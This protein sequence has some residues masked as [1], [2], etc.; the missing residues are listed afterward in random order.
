MKHLADKRRPTMRVLLRKGRSLAPICVQKT[1]EYVDTEDF[2][3]AI[4]RHAKP[5]GA[6][7]NVF[8]DFE[9]TQILVSNVEEVRIVAHMAAAYH[10]A[11][12]A[13]SLST[14]KDLFGKAYT[15]DTAA[16][17]VAEQQSWQHVSRKIAKPRKGAEH[18][19]V[20]QHVCGDWDPEMNGDRLIY[21]PTY[22]I[23]ADLVPWLT[24]PE[25]WEDKY[26]L[27]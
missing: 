18:K 20:G 7:E 9:N 12:L 2:I 5:S 3:L 24:N 14:N 26:G 25:K 21:D 6:I 8:I 23:N 15:P 22:E 10:N 11:N 1:Q 27:Y 4:M 16:Q 13:A 17:A 19:S